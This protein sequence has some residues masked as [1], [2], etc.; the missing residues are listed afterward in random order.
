MYI[1]F[2]AFCKKKLTKYYTRGHNADEKIKL[3]TD[4]ETLT[5]SKIPSRVHND[6]LMNKV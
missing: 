6:A 3:K 4:T 5:T 2:L 1:F